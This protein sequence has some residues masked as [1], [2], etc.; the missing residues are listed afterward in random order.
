MKDRR[1]MTVSSGA[2]AGIFV[3]GILILVLLSSCGKK[4]V[5]VVS[6]DSRVTEEA[7][8]VAEALRTAYVEKDFASVADKCSKEGFKE[9][10]DSIKHF[11]S[12]ELE[13]MPRWV[14]IDKTKVYLNIAWK[15]SWVVGKDTMSERGMAVFMLDGM[16]LKLVKI[17]RGNPFEYPE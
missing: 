6:Q 11:D 2:S 16:P 1:C 14:E 17:E 4:E 15:G 8:S 13:F 5:K 7:F 12:V 10:M 9:F 3:I